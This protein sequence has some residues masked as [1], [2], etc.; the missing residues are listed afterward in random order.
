MVSSVPGCAPIVPGCA[1][2]VLGYMVRQYQDVLRQYQDVLRQYQE[3]LRQYDYMLR[4][5]RDMLRWYQD[6]LCQYW[7]MLRWSVQNPVLISRN[8]APFHRISGSFHG[9]ANLRLAQ[10]LQRGVWLEACRRTPRT[11]A[12][13]P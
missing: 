4:Q 11:L 10:D 13:L 3:R 9:I 7:D 2:P 5:Y 6:M 1:R 12:L 8:L